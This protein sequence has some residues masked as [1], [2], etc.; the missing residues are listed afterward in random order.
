[1]NQS[2]GQREFMVTAPDG[3]LVVFGQAIFEMPGA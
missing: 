2:Y 1:V 3:D